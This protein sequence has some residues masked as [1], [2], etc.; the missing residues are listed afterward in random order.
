MKDWRFKVERTNRH[1][2]TRAAR[3]NLNTAAA[4]LSG[5]KSPDQQVKL[6]SPMVSRGIR[7]VYVVRLPDFA[8]F[9][10]GKSRSGEV[11]CIRIIK[12]DKS[13]K[14][15]PQCFLYFPAKL[16][17]KS[18]GTEY[19]LGVKYGTNPAWIKFVLEYV[20]YAVSKWA[21]FEDARAWFVKERKSFVKLV[22]AL[23]QFRGGND[24]P[25]N[26]F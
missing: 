24:V 9:K 25:A 19:T 7:S 26:R 15:P 11:Q 17:G 20:E 5:V 13:T 18:K 6:V 3:R 10:S 22:K 2:R 4:V 23:W 21:N 8:E 1:E 16:V 12:R 14:D